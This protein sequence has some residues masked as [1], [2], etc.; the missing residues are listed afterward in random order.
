VFGRDIIFNI[1]HIVNWEYIKQRK[2]KVINLNNNKE[3]SKRVQNVYQVEDKVL[4]HRGTESK[5]E[6]PYQ[7]PFVIMQVNDNGT[8]CLKVNAVEDTYNI[9]RIIPY[10]TSPDPDHGGECNVRTSKKR[11]K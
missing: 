11:R 10:H 2:Q 1:Q 5:Y 4:L 6:S 7:G 8:I 3:N 9:R